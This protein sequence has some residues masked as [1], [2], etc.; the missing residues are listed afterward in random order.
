MSL[1]PSRLTGANS[2]AEGQVFTLTLG[3]VSD[4]GT[5]TVTKYIVYWG[6]GKSDMYTT[7]GPVTHVYQGA[8]GLQV[9]NVHLVDE[10]VDYAGQQATHPLA[11]EHLVFVTGAAI[12]DRTLFILGFDEDDLVT[13]N[14]QGNGLTKVHASFFVGTNFKTFKTA[15]FDRI[16]IYLNGGQD[17]ANIAG[18]VSKPVILDGGPGDDHLN[19]GG[20]GNIILG[21]PGNDKLIGGSGRDILIGG[22]GKDDLGGQQGEDILIGGHTAYDND[23]FQWR[24]LNALLQEWMSGRDFPTRT[25]N[26]LNGT[27]PILV[28]SQRLAPSQTVFDDLTVDQLNGGPSA[29]WFFATAA[30]PTADVIKDGSAADKTTYTNPAKAMDVNNDGQVSPI[31]ALL[32]VNAITGQGAGGAPARGLKAGRRRGRVGQQRRDD[33]DD[34]VRRRQWR[35]V[36]FPSGCPVDH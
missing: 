25:S 17:H 27:G 4:P 32:V 36:T 6:D 21:G 8:L 22:L 15:D 35:R 9:V 13:V 5:D 29:D 11:G 34:G 20:R 10:D 33:S 14:E 26:L 18:N 12:V 19:G 23:I 28:S 16:V 7:P 30:G 24:S 2:V 1:R 31:D 3:K